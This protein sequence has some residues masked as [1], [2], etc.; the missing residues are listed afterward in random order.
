M[1]TNNRRQTVFSWQDK[2]SLYENNSSRPSGMETVDEEEEEVSSHS[3]SH[4][5]ADHLLMR[6]SAAL[7]QM[8]KVNNTEKSE[9]R[10]V[11]QILQEREKNLEE[12]KG[13][14]ISQTDIKEI[15]KAKINSLTSSLSQAEEELIEAK[16]SA[17]F[18]L[19]A[20]EKKNSELDKAVNK[21]Q[22]LNEEGVQTENDKE[23]K[24][25]LMAK[26][27]S[28]THSLSVA[29]IERREVQ[30]ILQEREKN[31]E[32]LKG[33]LI[34][35]TDIKEILK[36]KINSLTSS[37]SQAEEELIE[38]KESAQF[39]LEALEKKNSELDKAV[40]KVQ[41]LNEEGVQTEN[42]KEEKE[43]LMAKI[44]SLTHSLSVAESERREVQQILQEREKTLG[45]L[46]GHLI[47]QT[48]IK[49]ILMGKI[50]SLTSSLSQ[51]E[52][53]LIEAKE[54]A[55]FY[56]E[57]LEKKNS[58]L[59]KAVNKVQG[60]NEEGVQTENDKE[61]KEILMAKINSLTHSLSV[62]ESERREVQQILQEREKNLEEL[63]GHLISQ[64]DI[65]EILKA[66][67]NSLT[68][69]LS[70][71]EEELIEA[72]ESAQFY[73]EALEKKNSELE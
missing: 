25:I 3:P 2:S 10:E 50:N 14:L 4:P 9:R 56:L 28:L 58:E 26:I 48:D 62:A 21:V 7:T 35:Q 57:A 18:Y 47:S 22:G 41:G 33:H 6:D 40:N 71:A 44:N 67:I 73:L 64:T 65:K 1:S 13:H 32:E 39:Y 15:L 63:K 23:E 24:E 43:I 51:A 69:S 29:E 45:E 55:Q 27:N 52:E 11:Q 59:D 60:L 70:Q 37:L 42:D 12:L 17:Q 46:K 31:L 49:E 19:E 34:S 5:Q 53:E 61:E 8:P 68:S 38:A 20:L 54:S 36:A 16:E 30:Q 66:K 72:K